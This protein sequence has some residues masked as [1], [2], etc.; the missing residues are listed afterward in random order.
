MTCRDVSTLMASGRLGAEP[1]F[2]RLL[3]HA[4]LAMCRHCRRFRRQIQ[5]LDAGMRRALADLDRGQPADLE[6]RVLSR[7]SERR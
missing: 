2:R 6:E 5:R 1:W 3:A 7:L 4:H